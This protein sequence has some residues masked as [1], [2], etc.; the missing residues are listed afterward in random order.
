MERIEPKQRMLRRLKCSSM[1]DYLYDQMAYARKQHD[2]F[3]L[4]G[5]VIWSREDGNANT[6]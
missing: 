6:V 1:L 4:P 2:D 5:V 3:D